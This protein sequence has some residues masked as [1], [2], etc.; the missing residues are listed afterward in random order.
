MAMSTQE[1]FVDTASSLLTPF[2][3][4]MLAKTARAELLGEHI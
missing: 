2:V 1:E 4:G 3:M